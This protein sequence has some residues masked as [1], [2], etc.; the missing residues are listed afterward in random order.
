MEVEGMK[1][2]KL[3]YKTDRKWKHSNT[4]W[5]PDRQFKRCYEM[6]LF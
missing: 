1:V 6:A 4:G 2:G 5:T 3:V